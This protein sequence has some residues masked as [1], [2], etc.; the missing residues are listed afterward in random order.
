MIQLY[1]REQMKR[2]LFFDIFVFT[3]LFFN[4]LTIESEL[5][6]S[7]RLFCFTA[8]L[9]AYY[10]ALWWKDWRFV[11]ACAIG[12][13]LFAFVAVHIDHSLLIYLFLFSDVSGRVRFW[14]YLCLSM[15]FLVSSYVLVFTVTTGEPLSFLTTVYAPFLFLQLI[16][17]VTIRYM[18]R[19]HSLERDL[20]SAES[21]LAAFAK[22]EE[23]NRIARD[24]HDTL[25]H[26]LAVIKFKS[27][28]AIRLADS[29]PVAAKQEMGDVLETARS[30]AKQVREVV[31]GLKHIEIKPEIDHA[32]TLFKGT[33]TAFSVRGEAEIPILT[34]VV[35]TMVALSIREALV[36][37]YKHSR[38]DL[39]ELAFFHTDNELICHIRDDGV[40]IE[41]PDIK[42]GDGIASMKERMR[43]VGGT[44]TWK[45]GIDSGT[46]VTL[47]VPTVLVK[48][49]GK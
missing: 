7:L 8:I 20:A 25:G 21:E 5:P 30:A 12:I 6:L 42:Q 17:P 40:G 23:R 32:K 29:N 41:S 47:A 1:P 4:L 3:F 26:T 24:L 14:P 13:C 38:A 9:A 15:L 10:V 33:F 45:S 31:A 27:E 39:V 34:E 11:A 49:E 46:T 18:K 16:L 43:L 37:C 36:N 2:Y 19:A 22:E 44:C 35:E 48:G 28:L